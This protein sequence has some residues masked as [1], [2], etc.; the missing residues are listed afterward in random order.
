VQLQDLQK[1]VEVAPAL[2]QDITMSG[3]LAA[4]MELVVTMGRAYPA[5]YQRGWLQ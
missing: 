2:K 1:V 5:H 4:R 3:R